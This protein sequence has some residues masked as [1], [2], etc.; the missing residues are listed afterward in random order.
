MQYSLS[1]LERISLKTIRIIS[2]F[3]ITWINFQSDKET[4]LS[5]L[6]TN[7]ISTLTNY[8]CDITIQLNKVPLK[9]KYAIHV[10]GSHIHSRHGHCWNSLEKLLFLFRSRISSNSI[11]AR[12]AWNRKLREERQKKNERGIRAGISAASSFSAFVL[13][14]GSLLE[15]ILENGVSCYLRETFARTFYQSRS[16]L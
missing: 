7:G 16:R 3:G 10:E 6:H 15:F 8:L 5:D 14:V 12:F 4:K 11:P 9:G 1:K 2:K 13:A